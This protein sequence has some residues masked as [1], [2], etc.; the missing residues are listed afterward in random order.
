VKEGHFGALELLGF[1]VDIDIESVLVEVST[2]KVTL[3]ETLEFVTKINFNNPKKS[4]VVI[5]Y[6][7]HF[8]KA[9]GSLKPKVFKL[10]TKEI[11]PQTSLSLTK[12]HPL[13]PATT[14]SYYE[15]LQAVQLQVNG[16]IV[17]ELIPFELFI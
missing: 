12:R 9:N 5:D 8:K 14:R 17:T 3:G 11:G 2:P 6:L 7:L 15:G 10:S 4:K 13:K 1:D 16:K